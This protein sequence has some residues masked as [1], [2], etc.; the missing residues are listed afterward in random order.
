MC[1]IDNVI[2]K[3]PNYFKYFEVSKYSRFKIY[4]MSVICLKELQI[5][6][7]FHVGSIISFQLGKSVSHN[8]IQVLIKMKFY[9]L[10]SEIQLQEWWLIKNYNFKPVAGFQILEYSASLTV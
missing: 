10:K 2:R 1:I 6:M 7:K 9:A 5:E 3:E 4:T 8:L